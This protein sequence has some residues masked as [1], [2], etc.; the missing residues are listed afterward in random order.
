MRAHMDL[1]D[2]LDA[3]RGIICVVGAGGKKSTLYRLAAG[4]TGRVAITATVHIPRFPPGVADEIVVVPD[5]TTLISIPPSAGRIIAFVGGLDKPNRYAGLAPARIDALSAAGAFDVWLVKADGA[6]ARMVKAPG[7]G[8][9]SLPATTS[10]V[11]PVV[12]ARAIGRALD[13]ATAHRPEQFAAVTGARLGAPI[14]AE[15]VGRL[16]AA[17]DG[18]LKG[19]GT[20]QVVPV[21]NMVDDDAALAAARTAAGIALALTGRYDRVVLARMSSG[22]VVEIIRSD[23]RA[24]A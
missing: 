1:V 23:N 14:T 7:A 17:P 18:M 21:I 8:E 19:V 10:T 13:D 11:I 15:H 4:H 12:S 20:A 16:L 5:E 6:R 24:R 2:V 3:R 22:A 9:P